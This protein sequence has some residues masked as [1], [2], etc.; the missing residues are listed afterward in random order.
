MPLLAVETPEGVTLTQPIAGAGSR[1]AAGL[2]DML[3][4]LSGYFT[5]VLIALAV[6]AALDVSGVSDFAAGLLIGGPVLVMILYHVGFH[7]AWNGQ[8]P[9]KRALGIR[10]AGTDGYAASALQ[11]VLRG[12]IWPFD[13]LIALPVPIG[14]LAIAATARNQRL[15]DLV[16]GT[17]VL[18]EPPAEPVIEP[19]PGETW[20]GLAAR[21]AGIAPGMAARLSAE[22]LDFLRALLTRTGLDPNERRRLF[23]AAARHYGEHLGLGPFEDARV[24]LREVYLLARESSRARASP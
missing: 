10:V 19:W 21:Q 16:A 13:V 17:L 5:L 8:T 23:V 6:G 3:W 15:G 9:G 24:V 12:L 20:S 1:L 18:R 4:I 2:L 7:L 14:L 11:I 22:D